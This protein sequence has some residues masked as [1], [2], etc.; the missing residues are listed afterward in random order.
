MSRQCGHAMGT[1]VAEGAVR[2]CVC[3]AI[4]LDA[5][6]KPMLRESE[7]ERLRRQLAERDAKYTATQEALRNLAGAANAVYIEDDAFTV[8]REG[9]G[10]AKRDDALGEALDFAVKALADTDSETPLLNELRA[11]R[12]WKFAAMK[13]WPAGFTC[14]RILSHLGVDC[15]TAKLPSGSRC[16]QCE[17]NELIF[18]ESD[19]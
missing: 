6:G 12:R 11:L 2:C 4:E 17:I 8:H 5:D 10:R 13:A 1:I 3:G 18:A 15:E 7:I 16:P 19:S 14:V 9:D